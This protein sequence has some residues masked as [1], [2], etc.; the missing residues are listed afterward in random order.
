MD[1]A[2]YRW[3]CLAVVGAVSAMCLG[4]RAQAATPAGQIFGEARAAAANLPPL[5]AA[6]ELGMIDQDEMVA[7]PKQGLKDFKA[8]YLKVSQWQTGGSS[9]ADKAHVDIQALEETNAIEAYANASHFEEALAWL[10]QLH[11]P[12]SAAQ[13][14]GMVYSHVVIQML[15]HKQFPQVQAALRQCASE[16]AGYPYE[17]AATALDADQLPE[18]QRMSI[19]SQGLAAPAGPEDVHPAA[20]FFGAVVHT[21]PAMAGQVES[22][23]F[24]LL[25]SLKADSAA[26]R[27]RS[28]VDARGGSMLL[29]VLDQFD[30]ERAQAARIQYPAAAGAN[31]GGGA[32]YQTS[33]AGQVTG[34]RLGQSLPSRLSQLAANDPEGAIAGAT[35]LAD[36]DSRFAALA[37]IAQQLAKSRPQ[38]AEQSASQAFG[39]LDKDVAAAE[40]GYTANLADVFHDLGDVEKANQVAEVALS[41]ADAHAQQAEEQFDLSTPEAVAK[42]THDL[43][44]PAVALSYP[45]DDLAPNFPSLALQHARGCECK[46]AKPLILAKIAEGMTPAG[47]KAVY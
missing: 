12:S 28:V 14:N 2:G 11:E 30:P 36:R 20:I 4:A 22:A 9:T 38:M 23:M 18:L 33:P 34:M 32:V 8:L 35:S 40:T 21:F 17:G 46:V 29:S 43:L 47:A 19:A 6:R 1:W 7:I 24:A 26:H 25:A 39:L 3:L 37:G 27:E 41:A 13:T 45:Y 5:L 10:Q 15:V 16:G 44:L 31:F 42:V